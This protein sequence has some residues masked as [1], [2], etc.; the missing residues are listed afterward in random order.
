M[1]LPKPSLLENP[2]LHFTS[3]TY[4]CEAP[5]RRLFRAGST[6]I[7]RGEDKIREGLRLALKNRIPTVQVHNWLVA[8][9]VRYPKKWALQYDRLAMRPEI[10]K[11]IVEKKISWNA[12]T[13]EVNPPAPQQRSREAIGREYLHKLAVWIVITGADTEIIIEELREEVDKVS[14]EKARA[15]VSV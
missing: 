4:Q 3:D 11:K 1:K 15:T 5:V 14:A 9:D 13:R 8:E 6:A 10:A 2:V 7:A 12:G